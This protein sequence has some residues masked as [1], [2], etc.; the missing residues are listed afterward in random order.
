MTSPRSC[1]PVVLLRAGLALAL[2]AVI[3]SCMVRSTSRPSLPDDAIVDPQGS[4]DGASSPGTTDAGATAASPAELDRLL[5]KSE[6]SWRVRCGSLAAAE[7]VAC[8]ETAVALLERLPL[9]FSRQ[10]SVAAGR[11]SF[12]PAAAQDC[13]AAAAARGCSLR[14]L[15]RAQAVCNDVYRGSVPNGAPCSHDDECTSRF[16]EGAFDSGGCSGVCRPARTVGQACVLGGAPCEAG[17]FCD[18]APAT[19]TARR[20]PGA[21]C[22][23]DSAC[24]DGLVCRR[25]RDVDG[26]LG[27]GACGP[28]RA[29]GEPCGSSY[30]CVLPSYCDASFHCAAR[31]PEGGPCESSEDCS[32]GTYCDIAATAGQCR[33]WKDIG[34]ACDPSRVSSGCPTFA[35]CSPTTSSCTPSGGPGQECLPYCRE[36]LHCEAGVCKENIPLGSACTV[37]DAA[38]EDP[39]QYGSCTTGQCTMACAG[40]PASSN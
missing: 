30:E 9:P 27:A 35:P 32:S 3:A 23:S 20:Q 7:E 38:N 18:G 40:A 6:C 37:P 2:L 33:R 21:R 15:R 8:S 4:P 34:A 29:L 14:D 13:A 28:V 5:A 25:A 10:A 24:A 17:T 39:C 16:C 1:S 31:S 11:M 22:D 19:C 26:G 12:A 36:G